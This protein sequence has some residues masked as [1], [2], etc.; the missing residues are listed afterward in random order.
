MAEYARIEAWQIYNQGVRDT[1]IAAFAL[2][3]AKINL[4]AALNIANAFSTWVSLPSCQQLH[5]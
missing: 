3:I 4:R 5:P 1:Q 2:N